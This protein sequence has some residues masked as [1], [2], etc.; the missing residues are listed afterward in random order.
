MSAA[1]TNVAAT[2]LQSGDVLTTNGATVLDV[3]SAGRRS[4]AKLGGTSDED[5]AVVVS[6]LTT[7]GAAVVVVW[8][9][10]N[11]MYIWRGGRRERARRV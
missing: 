6:L 11:R 4:F 9:A 3:E 2:A 1:L 5:D 7:T 10:S 8:R